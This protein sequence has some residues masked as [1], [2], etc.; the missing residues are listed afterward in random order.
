MFR[1]FASLWGPNNAYYLANEA[2][3][4]KELDAVFDEIE[5]MGLFA[6]PSLGYSGWHLSVNKARGL[7]ESMNDFVRDQ[8]SASQVAAVDYFDKFTKRYANR[9]CVLM[10]ELGNE[11]NL[12]VNLPP[13]HDCGTEQCF[14]TQEMVTLSSR[15]VK[16]IRA[17]DTRRPISSGYS[18]PRKSAWH[19]ENCPTLESYVGRRRKTGPCPADPSSTGYWG[20]DSRE[21][22]LLQLKLQ[23]AAVDVWSIHVYDQGGYQGSED[24]WFNESPCVTSIDVVKAASQEAKANG[25]ML[26]VGEYGGKNPHF[27]GPSAADQA[28]PKAILQAQIDDQA[29]NGSFAL[30][31]IWAWA[32]ASH[33]SDMVCIY[34]NSTIDKE[35]GSNEMIKILNDANQNLKNT[36]LLV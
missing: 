24:C 28:F 26:Y 19:N 25:A 7:N 8:S 10:W 11:L 20:H 18:I 9:S 36:A 5:N 14:N 32:C 23:N 34:P 3:Y 21:Q 12:Q 2:I 17:T 16:T 4:W 22:W 33:R 13:G 31:S 6:I 15:L 27:T 30:S 1:F 29:N 35:Q